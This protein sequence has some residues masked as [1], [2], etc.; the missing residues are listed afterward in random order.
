MSQFPGGTSRAP[1]S[2]RG[3]FVV[4]LPP[5][6]AIFTPAAPGALRSFLFWG[7]DVP[8]CRN[9]HS[10][11]GGQRD[12]PG[13]PPMTTPQFHPFGI[14][15]CAPARGTGVGGDTAVPGGPNLVLFPPGPPALP[16][17]CPQSPPLPCPCRAPTTGS[18]RI[19]ATTAKVGGSGRLG[20]RGGRG[21]CRQWGASPPA[22]FVPPPAGGYYPVRIGDVFNGRYH[23][24]RKLGWG[25]F[26]TVWLCWDMR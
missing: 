15:L 17:M 8:T 7:G 16:R 18:R 21:G 5:A 19:P 25:H 2:G 24:V 11:L 1:F 20:P 13:L 10:G 22:H 23:V 9:C 26:S 6:S 4:A 3:T 14:N 12:L